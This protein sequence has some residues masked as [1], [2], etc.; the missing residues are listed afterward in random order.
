MNKN[1]KLGIIFVSIGIILLIGYLIFV[2]TALS[3]SLWTDNPVPA[4][5]SIYLGLFLIVP[6]V[7][8]FTIGF[9]QIK[10]SKKFSILNLSLLTIAVI[11]IPLASLGIF[12]LADRQNYN[13]TYTFTPIKWEQADIEDRGRLID[14]FRQQYDLV[15]QNIDTVPDLLGEPNSQ[16]ELQYIYDIGDYKKWLSIDQYYYVITYDLGNIIIDEVIYQS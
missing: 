8:L 7:V 11:A 13:V 15:G 2:G 9:I 14:S 12:R 6:L 1:L 5:I 4:F 10:K 16:E 3:N